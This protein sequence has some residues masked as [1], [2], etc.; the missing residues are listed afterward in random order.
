MRPRLAGLGIGLVFGIVLS[1]SGMTSP[2]VIRSALLF[3]D[4]YLFLFFASAVATAAIGLQLLRRERR[5]SWTTERPARRHIAGSLV[6]G[7][8]WGVSDACPGPIATQVGQGIG[9]GLWTLAGVA[10]GVY[11]F[12][13]RSEDTEPAT[14][15]APAPASQLA[16]SA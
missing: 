8:G 4:S 15:P 11:L 2:E 7:I 14:D 12:L 5:V 13:R 6:F 9:W 16:P 10:L 3:E 1:W